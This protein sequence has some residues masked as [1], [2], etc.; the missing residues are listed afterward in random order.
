ML[1]DFQNP[2]F[3]PGEEGNGD[4][5]LSWGPQELSATEQRWGK[6][7]YT[8]GFETRLPLRTETQMRL[9]RI[10]AGGQNMAQ[11]RGA[12]PKDGARLERV[13]ERWPGS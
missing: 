13:A 12:R 2:D 9:C 7:G 6:A 11:S 8:I 4:V 1:P 5:E 3:P 10:W